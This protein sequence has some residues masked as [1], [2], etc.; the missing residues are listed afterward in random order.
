MSGTEKKEDRRVRRTRKLLLQALTRLMEEKPV[1]E[2]TVKELTDLADMNR[3][4]FYLYYKDIFD[5]VEK[6]ED[7]MFEGLEKIAAVHEEDAAR[8]QTGPI[9]QDLFHFVAENQEIVRVLLSPHGD[10]SFLH[11]LFEVIREKCLTDFAAAD[12]IREEEAFDDRFSFVVY[13]T[14]GVIRGW[15]NRGCAESAEGMAELA[16]GMIRNALGLPAPAGRNRE[17]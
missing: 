5:M 2:I 14:A 11:R 15:V 7:G 1:K 9:L 16:D 4:T 13:G 10:M 17:E 3:G 12:A 8:Q 6:I